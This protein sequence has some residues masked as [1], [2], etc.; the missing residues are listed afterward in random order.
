MT[1]ILPNLSINKIK[2]MLNQLEIVNNKYF[3][4]RQRQMAGVLEILENRMK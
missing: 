2:N 3:I 4:S 1:N